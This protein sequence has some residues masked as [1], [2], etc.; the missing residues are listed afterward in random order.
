MAT[1]NPPRDQ[2]HAPDSGWLDNLAALAERIVGSYARLYL[3][4][5]TLLTALT[6]TGYAVVKTPWM[7]ETLNLTLARLKGFNEIWAALMTG[8]QVDPPVLHTIQHYLLRYLG[9]EAF[10]ARMPAIAG[11][12]VMCAAI[13]ALVWRHTTPLYA[14]ATLF[15]PYATVMRTWGADARPYGMMMG[16]VALALLCWDGILS[17]SR[18]QNLWR[19]GMTLALAAAFSS[20][21]YSIFILLALGCG[22]LVK[23]LRRGR[24]DLLTWACVALATLAFIGWS[25]ILRSGSKRLMKHYFYPVQFKNLADF[26]SYLVASLP[27]AILLLC[28]VAAFILG[29]SLSRHRPLET[30]SD[31]YRAL[32]AAAFGFLL[33]PFA[34]YAAGVALTGFFVPYNHLIAAFGVV[35]GI[36]LLLAAMARGNR[37]V[38]L[39][40]LLA[41]GGHGALVMARGISGF[42][43][44]P[45][46]DYPTLQQMRQFLPDPKADIVVVSPLNFL[47]LYEANRHDAGN[48]ILYLYDPVKQLQL[49]GTDTADIIHEELRTRTRARIE[50]FDPYLA[51]HP[52]LYMATL[53][54]AKGLLEW[55]YDYLL[56][57]RRARFTW[58]GK[59]GDFNIW[60]VDQEPASAPPA[61]SPASAPSR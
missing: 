11:F 40:L 43:R 54:E 44:T 59:A 55:Q 50:P 36:P 4:L 20:H 41:M 22:E 56:K 26:Y 37:L 30:L 17:D 7:D 24:P 10:F 14:A 1:F 47:P 38:G 33:V 58:L 39:C 48:N 28:L 9:D 12:S 42:V 8:I 29:G 18:R 60:Q 23:W 13:S 49:T 3:L 53:G 34:G 32:L 27:L 31:S 15:V 25:P 61:V 2:D 51:T 52:R 21:F 6:F 19:L 46:S 45:G 16:W 57:Q 35:L 5:A